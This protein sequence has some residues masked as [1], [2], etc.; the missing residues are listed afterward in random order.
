MK[1]IVVGTYHHIHYA[2]ALSAGFKALGH[3]VMD[4]NY[5]EYK[6]NGPLASLLDSVQARYQIGLPMVKYNKDIISAVN[7]FHPDFVFF[8]RC[9]HVLPSTYKK[10]KQMK[11]RFFT[12]NNDDPMS[13]VPSKSFFRYFLAGVKLADHNFVYRPKNVE[14]Y[15]KI[16]VNNVS[17]LLPNYISA[18]NFYQKVPKDIPIGFIGHFENDGR[19][20]CVKALLDAGLPVTIYSSTW[21]R[22]ELYEQ[23]KDHILPPQHETAYNDTLNRIQLALVFYSRHNHDTYT[24][25]CFEIPVTKA[26]MVSEYTDDMNRMFPEDECAIYFRNP[27]ELV[28]KCRNLLDNP[29]EIQRIADNAYNRLM[30]LGGSEIDRA[31]E[32]ININN[33]LC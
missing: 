25:R 10:L 16:G 18:Y 20:K 6:N 15:K 27:D 32:V 31:K 26:V 11:C 2:A 17:I 1:I 24:R 19:D 5:S 21:N 33:M 12:Y 13:N 28:W 4:I 3:E 8:F 23:L 9:Y 22:S 14:D 30:E 29:V 7:N